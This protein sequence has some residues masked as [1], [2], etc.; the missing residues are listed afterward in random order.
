MDALEKKDLRI[1]KLLL[2]FESE[3]NLE[4]L[5]ILVE[6]QS[7]RGEKIMTD[8]RILRI[9]KKREMMKVFKM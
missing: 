8:S 4:I 9:R 6:F 2:F 7:R 3:R 5:N 1:L